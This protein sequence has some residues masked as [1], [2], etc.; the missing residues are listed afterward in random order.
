MKRE[1]TFQNDHTSPDWSEEKTLPT[2]A[3]MLSLLLSCRA[4]L[5]STELVTKLRAHRFD[6]GKC[7][8]DSKKKITCYIKLHVCKWCWY[9]FT[10][11][12]TCLQV[13][14]HWFS[15]EVTCLQLQNWLYRCNSYF[16]CANHTLHSCT[17]MS[18]FYLHTHILHVQSISHSQLVKEKVCISGLYSMCGS[19]E[20]LNMFMLIN[21]QL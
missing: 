21:G 13:L 12:I 18:L 2:R 9:L 11:H 17:V 19:L 3:V 5:K 7:S 15:K 10:R 20:M 6:I 8:F 14:L 4:A 16:T 1:S